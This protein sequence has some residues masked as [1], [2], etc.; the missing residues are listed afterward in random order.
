ME[1]FQK[2]YTGFRTWSLRSIRTIP[3]FFF[4]HQVRNVIKASIMT[5]LPP[6]VVYFHYLTISVPS[7]FVN[8]EIRGILLADSVEILWGIHNS[9]ETDIFL[10]NA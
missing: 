7:I 8:L 4:T 1:N 10:N 5:N 2:G 6:N 3:A 9:V